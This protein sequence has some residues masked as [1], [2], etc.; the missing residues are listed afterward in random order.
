M[1]CAQIKQEELHEKYILDKLDDSVVEIYL[2]HIHTCRSCKKDLQLEYDMIRGIQAIGLHVIKK[3][4]KNHVDVLSLLEQRNRFSQYSAYARAAIVTIAVLLP[5]SYLT[6][7]FFFSKSESPIRLQSPIVQPSKADSATAK[8]ESSNYSEKTMRFTVNGQII[9]VRI[10]SVDSEKDDERYVLP[11]QFAYI[12]KTKEDSVSMQWFLPRLLY[13]ID[14][15]AIRIA[16]HSE[17]SIDVAFG[18]L[19]Y[20]LNLMDDQTQAVLIK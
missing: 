6:N 2:E 7:K 12:F 4:L 5:A 3:E 13:N 16:R 1:D 19:V 17:K 8:S 14:S 18:N 11:Q 15:T 9:Q 20:R 10:V